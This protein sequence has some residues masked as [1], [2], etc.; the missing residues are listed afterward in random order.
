MPFPCHAHAV[1]LP[2]R[3]ANGLECAFPIWFTRCGRVLFTLAMPRLCHPRPYRF[4]QG[5]GTARPSRDGLWATCS[6]SAS[7]GYHAEFHEVVIRRIPTSDAGGQCETKHR[8][9]GRGKA[10][11]RHGLCELTH[12]MTGERHRRGMGTAF[13]VWIGLKNL[14]LFVLGSLWNLNPTVFV[15]LLYLLHSY[16]TLR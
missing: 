16:P 15:G 14:N 3:A 11:A 9:H 6:R 7:S 10:G 5:H 8:L 12:G 2:C 4:S 13:Y 1:P